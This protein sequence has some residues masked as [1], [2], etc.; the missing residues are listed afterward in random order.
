M[1]RIVCTLAAMLLLT[2]FASGEDTHIFA[3]QYDMSGAGDIQSALPDETRD[4]LDDMDVSPDNPQSMLDMTLNG[5]FEMLI[6]LVKGK[7]QRPVRVLLTIIGVEILCALMKGFTAS[8]KIG[9]DHPVFQV[10]STLFISITLLVPIS[11]YIEKIGELLNNIVSFQMTFVP[12]YALLI[13]AQRQPVTASGYTAALFAL[14]Q[15]LMVVLGKILLPL[16]SV[17]LAFSLVSAV[18][19][20]DNLKGIATMVRSA[21]I[22]LL[23]TLTT[24]FVAFLTLQGFLG[25]ATDNIGVRTVKLMMGSFIP[26]VGGAISEAYG[27]IQGCLGLLKTSVGIYGMLGAALI[28]LPT[29]LELVVWNLGL[30]LCASFGDMLQLPH[31]SGLIRSVGNV[32]KILI[33]V[34]VCCILLFLISTCVM[35]L[36]G[37]GKG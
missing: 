5:F 17:Y 21:T 1:K 20:G 22:F 24:V 18:S 13:T 14:C 15:I 7:S 35:L 16:L 3:Q 31:V 2:L 19:E 4:T 36:V 12:V 37:A 30:S 10:V 27:T 34:M 25:S 32:L 8:S 23:S 9:E 6:N 33:S 29:L 28:F 26:V 11:G